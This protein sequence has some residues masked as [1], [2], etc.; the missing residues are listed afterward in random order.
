MYDR[1]RESKSTLF[2]SRPTYTTVPVSLIRFKTSVVDPDQ[3]GSGTL[4]E[5]RSGIIVPDQDPAKH[6][7]AN[8]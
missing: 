2:K 6:E 1:E 5:S 4:P 7:R 3:H 8:K